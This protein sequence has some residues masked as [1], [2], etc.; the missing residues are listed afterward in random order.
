MDHQ[1]LE[2]HWMAILPF[3]ILLAMIA[4]APLCFADWWGSYYFKVAFGLAALVVCYF[5]LGLNAAT[6]VLRTAEEY[7][8]F[9]ALIGSLFVVS[10]GTHI[11]DEG[12]ATPHNNAPTYLS[13]SASPAP[14]FS[15]RTL[16]WQWPE[17]HGQRHHRPSKSPHAN[18]RRLH[19]AIHRPFHVPDARHR[20]AWFFRV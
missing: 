12:K 6:S 16:P 13:C 20:L 18:L 19:R 7:A 17:L 5:G 3:M 2:P 9:I 15:A 1:L 4:P 11:R 10:S 8:S 14:F